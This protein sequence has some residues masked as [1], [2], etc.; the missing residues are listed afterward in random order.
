MVVSKTKIEGKR[1][2]QEGLN[3][4]QKYRKCKKPRGSKSKK[5][6]SLSLE[7]RPSCWRESDGVC[8]FNVK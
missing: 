7:G 1:A 8:K 3:R 5:D 2:G 4:D 6:L